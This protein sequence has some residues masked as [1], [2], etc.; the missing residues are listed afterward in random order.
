MHSIS[1]ETESSTSRY[2]QNYYATNIN[3]Q[4]ATKVI[5]RMMYLFKGHKQGY[6]TN[7]K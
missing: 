5:N 6:L 1:G 7:L 2:V 4:Q 3:L